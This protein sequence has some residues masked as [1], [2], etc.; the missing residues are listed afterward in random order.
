[1]RLGSSAGRTDPGRKRRRN[2]DA[3]VVEPPL[4]AVADGMGGAQAGEVASRLAAAAFREYH[5]ADDLEPEERLKAI[6][7]EANRRIYERAQS[8][9]EVTG[10]GTTV[11]AA[12]FK[13][14]GV[15]IGHVGDSRAYRMRGAELEQLTSDHS[16]V[17]DLMR[18]GR[19]TPEEAESHPQRS[20]ITRALGTDPDIDVDTVTVDA[21]PGDLFL[22][23]SDGLTSMVPDDEI[24]E[25]LKEDRSL[26]STAKALVKAANRSGGEDNITVVLFSVEGE[27]ALEETLARGDGRGSDEE[28]E[29]TLS[30]LPVPP[31]L[32]AAG[33]AVVAPPA[34]EPTG[35]PEE[36]V[37][38]AVAE[39]PKP[40]P[41]RRRR[42][43]RRF[44]WAVV[45]LTGV[46]LLAAGAL[47]GLSRA[48]FVGADD[49]GN[50]TV[51]QGV[52][53]D[54]SDGVGLYRERYVSPLKASQL[55]P[56]ERAELFD[57]ELLSYDEAR[58]RVTEL[59][60]QLPEPQP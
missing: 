13:G 17:A 2:E 59:E 27:G 7:G 30:G 20:V 5:E 51:Y 42:W 4:F 23:C 53:F 38:P 21:S 41:P 12:L 55:S 56:E 14:D 29:D 32:A 16:L 39:P 3:Y 54:F 58:A 22:L 52:P 44:F 9:T 26:E 33:T 43:P 28:L 18:S 37:E 47:W 11:T 1:M 19:L 36:P 45:A 10:M 6:I 31:E 46:A 15:A 40:P 25:R 49:A 48:N 60:E 8:D 34:Q 35:W 24:L 50:I 57:H